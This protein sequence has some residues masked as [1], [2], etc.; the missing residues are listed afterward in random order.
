LIIQ[1]DN[2]DTGLD[3]IVIAMISSRTFRAN[4]PSRVLISFI[5]NEGRNSGLLSDSVVMTDNLATVFHQAIDLKVGILPMERVNS[6]LRHT[7][8]I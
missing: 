8:G 5:A 3:Q 6:A 1:A 4:H 2:L 7:L